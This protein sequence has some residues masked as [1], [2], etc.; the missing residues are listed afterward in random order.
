MKDKR[1]YCEKCPR[2]GKALAPGRFDRCVDGH[3]WWAPFKGPQEK[4]LRSTVRELLYGGAAGGGKSAAEV[5]VPLRY[6]EHPRFRALIL[7]RETTDLTPL[8]EMSTRWYPEVGGRSKMMGAGFLWTFPSGAKVRYSHCKSES[9]AHGYDGDEFQLICFD[10]LVQFTKTQY[11]N[12]ASRLRGSVAGLPRLLRCTTNPPDAGQGLWVFDWWAAWLDPDFTAPGLTPR[13]GKPPLDPGQTAWICKGKGEGSPDV[14]I[15]DPAVAR[16]WNRS[17]ARQEVED[18]ANFA[19]SRSFIPALAS[20]NLAIS[21]NDPEYLRT[22]AEMDPV[23]RAQLAKGDWL[24][25]P[26]PGWYFKRAWFEV[27]EESPKDGVR[28]RFWDRAATAE[29]DGAEPDWTVGVR[30]C[31]ARNMVVYVEDVIRFRGPPGEVQDTI[32]QTCV[33]DGPETLCLMS[34][35][36]GQAGKV[37]AWHLSQH[38]MG[39]NFDF[40]RESGDKRVRA[41]PLSAYAKAGNVKIVK[42]PWNKAYLAELELFPVGQFDDQ[43][44]ASSG[45]FALLADGGE[46]GG[47]GGGA[48]PF[49]RQGFDNVSLG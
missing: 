35:D 41:T 45:A 3:E 27:V 30:L 21:Q 11:L 9:D 47:G 7:R 44:D 46:A 4:F 17:P 8:L 43:V 48:P 32:K 15:L 39:H 5:M 34:L 42:A 29:Y 12:I 6:I 25:K 22:L 40:L 1:R 2:C 24:I 20:D 36:P 33:L 13:K 23:R 18:G 37:E 14:Y 26:S 49:P 16:E 28:I 31:I 10:E 38:L 19:I